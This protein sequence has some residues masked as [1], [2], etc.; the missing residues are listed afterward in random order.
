MMRSSCLFF[1]SAFLF[2]MLIVVT[3]GLSLA[4]LP[5][6]FRA[7]PVVFPLMA[8][9]ISSK[10]GKRKHPIHRVS[11]HHNGI[12]L[13]SPKGAH[14]RVVLGGTVVFA[15]RYKGYGKLVTVRHEEGYTSLYG[16][17]NEIRVEPGEIVNAG[18]I[19]GRVGSTGQATGP[20]L[21][22]EWRKNNVPIDPL[23]VFPSLGSKASG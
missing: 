2:S 19:V 21:H 1:T 12:D 9:R 3:P 16:H 6:I 8:P 15:G 18:Q 7:G 4:T 20:H 23:T 14:V 10:Y 22:F 5:A 13:A 11:K 17:L